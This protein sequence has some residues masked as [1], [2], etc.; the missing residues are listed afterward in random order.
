MFGQLTNKILYQSA[1]TLVFLA[2]SGLFRYATAL[3]C[4]AWRISATTRYGRL[5]I[6]AA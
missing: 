3:K 2:P 4:Y 1:Q 6:L 5:Q